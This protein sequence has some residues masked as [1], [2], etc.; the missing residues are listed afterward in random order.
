M[1][2]VEVQKLFVVWSFKALKL[3]SFSSHWFY[4]WSLFKIVTIEYSPKKSYIY[5]TVFKI[6]SAELYLLKNSTFIFFIQL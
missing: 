2:S 3:K 5:I 4:K 6:S 1:G